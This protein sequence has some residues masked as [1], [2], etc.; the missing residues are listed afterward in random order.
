[1]TYEELQVFAEE[2]GMNVKEKDIPGYHGRIFGN[3]IAI[4]QGLKTSAE[5][6]DTLAEEIGHYFTT[7]GDIMDQSNLPNRKQEVIA[8]AWA[9][10]QQIGLAGLISAYKHGCQTR[11]EAAEFLGVTEALLQEALEYY[12]NKYG[13]VPQEV[14]GGLIQFMPALNVTLKPE[15]M[16]AVALNKPAVVKKENKPVKKRAQHQYRRPLSSFD[17]SILKRQPEIARILGIDIRSASQK[18]KDPP[19]SKRW[20]NSI[21]E[22]IK[23]YNAKKK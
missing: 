4:H 17:L 18:V 21:N 11:Y 9:Y 5:K 23:T 1:M 10:Q 20:F 16:E 3:R 7:V 13:D 2:N 14:D 12:C 15:T 6:A 8:R 19:V 22:E